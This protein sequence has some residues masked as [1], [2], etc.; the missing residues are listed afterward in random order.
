MYHRYLSHYRAVGRYFLSQGTR[1]TR[2]LMSCA[3][4]STALVRASVTHLPAVEAR[5][6]V[7]LAGSVPRS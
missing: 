6:L 1:V 3:I 7:R 5:S 4:A 2:V